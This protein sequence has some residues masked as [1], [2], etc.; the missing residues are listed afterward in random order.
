MRANS[1][2]SSFS[3]KSLYRFMVTSNLIASVDWRYSFFKLFFFLEVSVATIDGLFR[4]NLFQVIKKKYTARS[5]WHPVLN[6]IDRIKNSFMPTIKMDDQYRMI[7]DDLESLLNE[8]CGDTVT[9]DDAPDVTM[10]PFGFLPYQV[11]FSI[12]ITFPTK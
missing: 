10:K 6:N 11:T 1:S 9:T 8:S 2:S 7:I 12:S 5:G 3:F 4:H